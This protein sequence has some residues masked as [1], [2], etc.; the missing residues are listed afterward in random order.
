MSGAVAQ[1]PAG[2]GTLTG[3][4][5]YAVS[6]RSSAP[7]EAVWPLIGEADRWK[8]WSFLTRTELERP[9][10]P[11]PDGVGARRRFTSHGIGSTEEVVAFEPPRHLGYIILSGFPV[12]HYRADVVLEPDGSGT[13]VSWSGTF[14]TKIPGTGHLLTLVLR[15]MMGR[16]AT[17]AA[18]FAEGHP[19]PPG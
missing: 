10:Q 15:A 13:L 3:R 5:S 2:S 9:G 19:I 8:E 16:F 7:P 1:G 11:V 12:R 18:R 4:W 17:A 14:D 6:A